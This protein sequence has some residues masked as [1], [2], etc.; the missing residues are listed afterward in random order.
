LSKSTPEDDAFSAHIESTRPKTFEIHR[1]PGH[2][3]ELAHLLL[4]DSAW[5]STASR[6]A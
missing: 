5:T 6:T 2:T 3:A 1:L 4:T